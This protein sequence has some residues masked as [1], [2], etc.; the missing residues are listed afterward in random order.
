MLRVLHITHP[1]GGGISTYIDDLQKVAGSEFEIYTMKCSQGLVHVASYSTDNISTK[2]YYLGLDLKLTDYTN[3]KY[4]KI[5]SNI[6]QE[7]EIDIVQID[8]AVGHTFDIF[9]IPAMRELP[10]VCVIHDFYYICPTF[11]LVDNSGT[12]CKISCISKNKCNALKNNEY[13]YSDFDYDDLL[14][15]RSIFTSVKNL[16]N[17]FVF[18]S[19]SAKEIFQEFYKVDE[20][21]CKVIGHGSSL[22]K[23]GTLA[24]TSDCGVL[25][26]GILGSMLKHKGKSTIQSIISLMEN[27][28]VEFY[29]FGDGDLSGKKLQNLGRYEQKNIL[30]LL[31][32]KKIDVILL[33]SRWPETFSYTLSESISANI[34]SIVSNLGA[35]AERVSADGFGW[36]VD[37][38]DVEGI[39]ALIESLA[40]NKG[41]ISF[42]REKAANIKLKTLHEMHQDYVKLYNSICFDVEC[43]DRRVF[44]GPREIIIDDPA[45]SLLVQF[46]NLKIITITS[47]VYR[48]KKKFKKYFKLDSIFKLN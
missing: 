22:E 15:F 39:C 41:E 33:L 7:L 31:C 4:A 18:P 30:K 20:S 32:D 9:T 48:C 19:G 24:P 2:E 37:F 38:D 13:L 3:A 25:R 35:L 6:L 42:F 10:I 47:L 28:P 17:A 26:V 14:K 36:V 23:I 11:H 45:H 8:S 21:K 1:W 29:H 46:V 12:Y 27:S 43:S 44:A 34:P 5:L 16:I 40:A